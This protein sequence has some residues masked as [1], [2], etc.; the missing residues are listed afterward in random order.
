MLLLIA[1]TPTDGSGKSKGL[2]RTIKS[3]TT[4]LS[5][6]REILCPGGWIP[7]NDIGQAVTDNHSAGPSQ[8][9]SIGGEPVVV[10]QRPRSSDKSEPQFLEARSEEHTSE[11]QSLRHIVCR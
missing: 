2:M 9:I 6:C 3:L 1:E 5:L 11:L 8:A 10:L 4:Y 7:D